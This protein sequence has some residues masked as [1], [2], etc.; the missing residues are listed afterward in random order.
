MSCF[1]KLKWPDMSSKVVLESVA[2]LRLNIER[3]QRLLI[4]EREPVKRQQITSLLHEALLHEAEAVGTRLSAQ[5]RR[6]AGNSI[7]ARDDPEIRMG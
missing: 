6:I 5:D 4:T 1:L 7:E 3:Y 2:I